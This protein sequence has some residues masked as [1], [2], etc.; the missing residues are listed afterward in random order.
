MPLESFLTAGDAAK[1]LRCSPDNV[2]RL[3]RTGVLPAAG[4]TRSELRPIML[5]RLTDVERVA[6]ARRRPQ[7]TPIPTERRA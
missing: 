4:V 6:A 1:V 5:Y 3:T 7:R 2:R